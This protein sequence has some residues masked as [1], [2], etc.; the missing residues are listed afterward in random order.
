MARGFILYRYLLQSDTPCTQLGLSGV[1]DSGISFVLYKPD[2]RRLPGSH[3]SLN[4]KICA[5]SG[6]SAYVDLKLSPL[7]VQSFSGI[8]WNYLTASLASFPHQPQLWRPSLTCSSPLRPRSPAPDVQIV[9]AAQVLPA[10]GPPGVAEL[11][12]P[13]LH[14]M[15]ACP[16]AVPSLSPSRHQL[17]ASPLPLPLGHFGLWRFCRSSQALGAAILMC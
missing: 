10:L 1:L 17:L 13:Q 2:F 4:R 3:A 5:A 6:D 7:S 12:C 14:K 16:S 9:L 15:L 11:C 8:R